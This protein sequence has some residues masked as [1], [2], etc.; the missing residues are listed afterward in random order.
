MENKCMEK[1]NP[2][3]KTKN[4]Y[5]MYIRNFCWQQVLVEMGY[6]QVEHVWNVMAHAQK[7]Y[8][9][10]Q[11]NGQVHLNWQGGQYSQLLAAEMCT[12]AV[13]MVV[14]LDKPCSEVECK[15]TGY[16]LHSHVS[17]SLPLPCV[18]VCHQV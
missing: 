15:T 8:L 16:P 3:V 4:I 10:F 17:P 5:F 11:Q 9:V 1:K 18:T 14:M 6:C 12:S 7:P 2:S 13:V